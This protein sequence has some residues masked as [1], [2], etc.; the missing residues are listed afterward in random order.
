MMVAVVL[1]SCLQ[2]GAAAQHHEQHRQHQRQLQQLQQPRRAQAEEQPGPCRICGIHGPDTVPVPRKALPRGLNLP[3]PNC[4]DVETAALVVDDS[5]QLCRA[6]QSFGTFC[7]C[8]IAPDACSLCWDGSSV[9]NLDAILS[10]YSVTP[11]L[12]GLGI[13]VILNCGLLQE[14]LQSVVLE[15][16]GEC[17]SAQMD[18]GEQCGCPP[19]PTDVIQNRTNTT[20]NPGNNNNNNTTHQQPILPIGGSDVPSCSLCSNGEPSPFPDRLVTLSTATPLSCAEYDLFAS[21]LSEDSEDC[22][23]VRLVGRSCGCEALPDECNLCPLGERVP[24]PD[25]PLN[26]FDQPNL[27]TSTSGLHTRMGSEF[28]TCQIMESVVASNHWA[29]PSATSLDEGLVCTSMQM[30]SWICGCK[31]D[32]RPIV[33]TWSYRLSAMLSFVVSRYCCCSEP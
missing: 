19:I 28:L 10:N 31:Q 24:K 21:T 5:S 7:G 22:A 20:S 3:V 14:F 16:S 30:K 8:N 6:A 15:S 2:L 12:G 17:W 4:K 26:W 18:V 27:S 11:F 32:W 9:T 25:Q 29:V 23:V 33:L 1:L 13:N